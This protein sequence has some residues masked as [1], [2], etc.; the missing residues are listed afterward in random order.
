MVPLQLFDGLTLEELE[1][2]QT[3]I[4]QYQELVGENGW[5]DGWME[6]TTSLYSPQASIL[7]HRVMS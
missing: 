7:S 6:N 1:Q 5:V 3:E 4:L 2:L